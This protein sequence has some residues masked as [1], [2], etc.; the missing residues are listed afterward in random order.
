MK[1]KFNPWIVEE[2]KSKG[3][4]INKDGTV[5]VTFFKK[6]SQV[7]KDLDAAVRQQKHIIDQQKREQKENE[8]IG[9]LMRK[10]HDIV[11]VL[12]PMTVK[13]F[14]KAKKTRTLNRLKTIL[15]DMERT[16]EDLRRDGYKRLCN[17]YRMLEKDNI[18]AANVASMAALDRM[19]RRWLVNSKEIDK[20]FIRYKS[21][22][23]LKNEQQ[24]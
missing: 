16:R 24:V 18:P 14:T 15:S 8:V 10:F 7:V 20:A 12:E 13:N 19:R 4:I 5:E 11:V 22:L 1:K 23:Q 2:L 21:L 3:I 17:V 6:K 9:K